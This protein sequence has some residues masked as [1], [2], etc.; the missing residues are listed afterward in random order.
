MMTGIVFGQV[1]PC[2]TCRAKVFYPTD[3]AKRQR[4]SE[5]A[6]AKRHGYDAPPAHSLCPTCSGKGYVN[7]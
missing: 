5:L 1:K 7:G 6:R 3:E 4:A 2:P